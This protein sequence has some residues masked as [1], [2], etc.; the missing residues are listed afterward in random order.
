MLSKHCSISFLVSTFLRLCK[1]CLPVKEIGNAS[2]AGV[3]HVVSVY[4]RKQ[5]CCWAWC[6][7]SYHEPLWTRCSLSKILPQLHVTWFGLIFEISS[8]PSEQFFILKIFYNSFSIVCRIFADDHN[9]L[10]LVFIENICTV[11]VRTFQ[12][13]YVRMLPILMFI[14][15]AISERES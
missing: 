5:N 14:F 11:C 10:R 3:N 8:K 9:N 2:R 13:Y 15:F 6:C 7:S 12:I 1:K 4:L